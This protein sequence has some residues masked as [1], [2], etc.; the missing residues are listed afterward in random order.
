MRWTDS[1][2]AAGV[3][4]LVAGCTIGR[5]YI[6]SELL[7]VPAEHIRPGETTMGEVLAVF[8]AP[9]LIHRRSEGDV[10]VYRYL[11]KNSTTLRIQE[12]LITR[13]TFFTYSKR[14]E[15]S[16]RLVV[17]FDRERRVVDYGVTSST[18]EL[19]PF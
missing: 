5:Q 6:G 2:L 1:L 12:P 9:E 15:K 14:Q 8:G 13:I 7:R 19:E 17:L 18:R 10:F 16:D 3:S 11:R 4:L